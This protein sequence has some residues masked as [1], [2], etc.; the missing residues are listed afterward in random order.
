MGRKHLFGKRR[1]YFTDI[2]DPE[3]CF[4]WWL[5][6][7]FLSFKRVKSQTMGKGNKFRKKIKQKSLLY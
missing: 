6:D 3:R 1:G 2:P 7:R 4:L 5:T